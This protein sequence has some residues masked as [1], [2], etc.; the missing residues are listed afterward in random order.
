MFDFNNNNNKISFFLK[1]YVFF[2]KTLNY[3]EVYKI[4]KIQINVF[5][6]FFYNQ[7]FQKNKKFI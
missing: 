7:H 1:N 5:F 2:S 3:I 6:L 4:N